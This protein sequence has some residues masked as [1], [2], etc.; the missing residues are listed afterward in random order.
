MSITGVL[1]GPLQNRSNLAARLALAS[2][3]APFVVWIDPQI[4]SSYACPIEYNKSF[5]ST[6][7]W[8]PSP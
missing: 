4:I 8:F 5:S 7:L 3:D 1:H 6:F 2:L